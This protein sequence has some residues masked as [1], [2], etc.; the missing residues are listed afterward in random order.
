MKLMLVYILML[1]NGTVWAGGLGG[2]TTHDQHGLSCLTA[3]S[4]PGRIIQMF[5][6]KNSGD[7]RLRG[8]HYTDTVSDFNVS[9]NPIEVIDNIL[10]DATIS[11]SKTGEVAI[12]SL[13]QTLN[14]RFLAVDVL[15]SRKIEAVVTVRSETRIFEC[16]VDLP[17]LQNILMSLN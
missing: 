9:F 15:L 2:G 3:S 11:K 5:L 6:F 16:H 10:E 14:L 17:V 8:L 7:D 13:S 1:I 4:Q 12:V